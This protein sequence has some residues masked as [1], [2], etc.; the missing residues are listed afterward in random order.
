MRICIP[1]QSFDLTGYLSAAVEHACSRLR[2]VV[3]VALAGQNN[4]LAKLEVHGRKI[5]GFKGLM[6]TQHPLVVKSYRAVWNSLLG[7]GSLSFGFDADSHLVLDVALWA[8]LLKTDF[9]HEQMVP[10]KV[11]KQDPGHFGYRCRTGHLQLGSGLFCVALV[12]FHG[13]PEQFG[14]SLR[15]W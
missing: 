11:A 6:A 9:V 3:E 8:L 7:Q 12:L 1:P 5:T 2:A 10:F 15:L 4:N 13:S 14:Y